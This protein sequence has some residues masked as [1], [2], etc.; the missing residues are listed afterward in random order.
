[1]W[2]V[3][4]AGILLAEGHLVGL[5][6]LLRYNIETI[7]RRLVPRAISLVSPSLSD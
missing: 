5:V 6:G 2:K 4:S 3:D 7:I 1:M